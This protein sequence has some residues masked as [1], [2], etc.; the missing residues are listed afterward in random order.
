LSRASPLPPKDSE[1]RLV[2]RLGQCGVFVEDFLGQRQKA[3]WI[4]R[5]VYRRHG[6]KIVDYEIFWNLGVSPVKFEEPVN[7]T[8]VVSG[9]GGSSP[10]DGC[11]SRAQAGWELHKGVVAC[12]MGDV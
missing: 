10:D 5:D 4:A 6:Y 8:N 2:L 9:T 11:V 12:D 1:G 3:V 7:R